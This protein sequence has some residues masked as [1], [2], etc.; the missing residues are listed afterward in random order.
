MRKNGENINEDVEVPLFVYMG[1]TS[2][3][4]VKDNLEELARYPTIIIECTFLSEDHRGS[5][6]DAKK[7]IAWQELF[8]VIQDLGNGITWILIHF[9][10]RYSTREIREFF[11]ER[12]KLGDMDDNIIL[13]WI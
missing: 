2:I 4:G 13:P 12:K 8:P 1:D 11:E 5:G 3:Q 9:S 7:H 10:M 6:L